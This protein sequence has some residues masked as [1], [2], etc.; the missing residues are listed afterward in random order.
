MN[1][2]QTKRLLLRRP[3][4]SDAKS[5]FYRYS[6]DNEVVKHL[7][8]SPHKNIEETEQ[9]IQYCLSKIDSGKA[10]IWTIQKDNEKGVIGMIEA[11]IRGHIAEMGYVLMRDEWGKGYMSE[12][13]SHVIDYV[14]KHSE[15]IRI[16]A[17]CDVENLGSAKVMEKCGMEREGLLKKYALHTNVSDAPR[18][19]YLY[20]ITK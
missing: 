5:I 20:A 1:N 7:T 15:V 4:L 9:F 2:I 16:Q 3:K 13:V 19:A 14:F 11:R 8:W 10:F 6:Q 17:Y 18:D 12:I